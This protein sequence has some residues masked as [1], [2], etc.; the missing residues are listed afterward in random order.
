MMSIHIAAQSYIDSKSSLPP[1]EA[2]FDGTNPRSAVNA[3]LS[4]WT[5]FH[6]RLNV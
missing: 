3:Q 4:I 2:Y 1:E 6:Q 5:G